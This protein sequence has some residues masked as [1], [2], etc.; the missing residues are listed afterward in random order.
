M[1][2]TD[3]LLNFRSALAALVPLVER[4]GIP[5]K[6]P[7]AYD[8]WDAMAAELF[9]NLVVQVFRWSLQEDTQETLRL[10][11][12]DL[13]LESYSELST[14]EVIHPALKPGRWIFNA[15]ET[16][17][18]PFDIVEVRLLSKDGLPITKELETCPVENVQFVLRL[19]RNGHS[20]ILEK[21][22]CSGLK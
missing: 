21:G 10:P 2:A 22:N 12:Y 13:M 5:W 15:F 6:R 9:N 3:I 19:L 7:D 20:V 8:E 18:S 16:E 1:T 4:V 11:S 14:I 17:A